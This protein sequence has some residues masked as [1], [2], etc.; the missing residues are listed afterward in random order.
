MKGMSLIFNHPCFMNNGYYVPFYIIPCPSYPLQPA[1]TPTN[2]VVSHR[3]DSFTD[4]GTAPLVINIEEATKQNNTFRTALWTGKH[5]QLTLMSINPGE[6]IGLEMHP[7]VDQFIRLEDGR[8]LV[9]MGDTKERLDF[10]RNVQDDDIFIIPAGKWH[11]LKNTGSQPIK[12]YSIY[13]PPEHPFGTVHET[14]AIADA[15]EQQYE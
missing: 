14:K 6:E 13:A 9:Q 2:E 1:Y 15:T 12:L 7:D 5:L 10:V 11:N 3:D 8:G 4:Y